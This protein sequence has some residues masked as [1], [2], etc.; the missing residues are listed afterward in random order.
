MKM[1]IKNSKNIHQPQV[2]F[3]LPTYYQKTI[4]SNFR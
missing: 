4:T 2:D 3:Y 1:E